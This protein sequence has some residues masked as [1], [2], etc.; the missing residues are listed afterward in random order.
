MSDFLTLSRIEFYSERCGPKEI[1]KVEEAARKGMDKAGVMDFIGNKGT[2]DVFSADKKGKT[3][4]ALH[5]KCPLNAKLNALILPGLLKN[6]AVS[7]KL[8]YVHLISFKL[9]SK[10]WEQLGSALGQSRSIRHL[11]LNV[12]NI[13]SYLVLFLQALTPNTTL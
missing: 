8:R 13:A 5:S 4:S 11:S 7:R 3:T 1:G 6:I 2:F 10:S 12:T 9:S